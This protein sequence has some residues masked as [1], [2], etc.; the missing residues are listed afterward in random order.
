M[1][2]NFDASKAIYVQIADYYYQKICSGELAPGEKLPSV[3]ETAQRLQVNPN[4]ASRSYLEMDRDGVTFSKRGQ[5]T[6]VTTDVQT[7]KKL[8]QSLASEQMS[9]LIAYLKKLGYSNE[10][11][12]EE[13]KHA[14]WE[15]RED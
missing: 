1:S 13:L 3:R 10:E 14:L 12:V 7:I 15:E 8:K 2:G 5:G 4:T 11:M 6:F 9:A